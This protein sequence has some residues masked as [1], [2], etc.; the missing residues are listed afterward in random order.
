MSRIYIVQLQCGPF[1]VPRIV[2]LVIYLISPLTTAQTAYSDSASSVGRRMP[3]R[4]K[5]T[6]VRSISNK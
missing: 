4:E 6:T 5:G 3:K 2:S 1:R